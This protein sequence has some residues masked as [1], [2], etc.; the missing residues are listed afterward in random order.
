MFK[1]GRIPKRL[2]RFFFNFKDKFTW[3][4]FN[5]FKMF[6]LLIIISYDRKNVTALYKLVDERDFHRSRY[7][8]FLKYGQLESRGASAFN[9]TWAYKAFK[10]SKR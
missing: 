3:N 10:S 4:Q 6:I 7:N 8:N 2:E 1:I 9:G 5:Y